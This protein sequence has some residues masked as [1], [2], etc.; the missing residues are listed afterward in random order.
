MMVLVFLLD[1]HIGRFL[2]KKL[3]SLGNGEQSLLLLIRLTDV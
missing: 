2:K 3:K 1:S